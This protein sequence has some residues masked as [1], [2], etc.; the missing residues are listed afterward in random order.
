[1]I[2]LKYDKG[3]AVFDNLTIASV[4]NMYFFVMFF[5]L[6]NRSRPN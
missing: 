1:M 2:F 3:Y 4:E 6:P 5:L